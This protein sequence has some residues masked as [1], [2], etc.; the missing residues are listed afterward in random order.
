MLAKAIA[1]VLVGLDVGKNYLGLEW[2][3]PH[4]FYQVKRCCMKVK[5][6][7]NNIEGLTYIPEFITLSEQ[8]NILAK[9]DAASWLTDLQRRVQHY[10]YKYDYKSRKVNPSDYIAPLPDWAMAIARRIYPVYSPTLPDQAIVNEYQP[11][12]GIANHVDCKLCFTHAIASLSLVSTCVMDFICIQT[13]ERL[14]LL[15]EPRSLIVMEGAARYD[16]THGIAKR[17]KDCFQGE[18][19]LRERRVSVTFRTVILATLE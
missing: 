16:W 18:V 10:G 6:H 2:G 19:I 7:T 14:S 8:K 9:I 1:L 11:G 5:E 12:Q 3:F 13:G 15:L 17:K 4:K